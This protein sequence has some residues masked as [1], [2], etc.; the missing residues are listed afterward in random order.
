MGFADAGGGACRFCERCLR[1]ELECC[2]PLEPE[3]EPDPDC[4]AEAERTDSSGCEALNTCWYRVGLL[5]GESCGLWPDPEAEA[6]SEPER[7]CL[8]ATE[9]AGSTP[10][11]AAEAPPPAELAMDEFDRGC[12]KVCWVGEGCPRRRFSET[13]GP[14]CD[15]TA[16]RRVSSYVDSIASS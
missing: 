11:A 5:T 15:V 1:N 3:P 6:E 16:E 10:F 12:G 7:M 9:L 13:G 2:S 14:S 4:G 8:S